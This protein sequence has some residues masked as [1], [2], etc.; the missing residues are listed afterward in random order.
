MKLYERASIEHKLESYRIKRSWCPMRVGYKDIVK[1]EE[2]KY[3]CHKRTCW[4]IEVKFEPI[5]EWR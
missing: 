2:G 4:D 3:D 1:C 5:I